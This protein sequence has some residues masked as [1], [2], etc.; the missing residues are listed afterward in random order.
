MLRTRI[1]ACKRKQ[2]GNRVGNRERVRNLTEDRKQAHFTWQCLDL[3]GA[4]RTR[5]KGEKIDP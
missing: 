5:K 4:I 1:E 3:E 2:K